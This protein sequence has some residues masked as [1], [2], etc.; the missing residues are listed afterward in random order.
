[1]VRTPPAR[2]T[3]IV[4]VKRLRAE[5]EPVQARDFLR[6]LFDW[7]LSCRT[8]GCKVRMQWPRCLLTRGLRA[9]AAAWKADI[10]PARI[11]EYD[12]HWLAETL[13]R[14]P[15]RMARLEPESRS[16][17]GAGPL[18]SP[19]PMLAKGTSRLVGAHPTARCGSSAPS[20]GVSTS[21]E[22][23]A[24]PF[25]M[26][27]PT[28]LGCCRFEVEEALAELVALGLVNSDSFGV[29]GVA[30]TAGSTKRIDLGQ[31]SRAAVAMFGMA[32][33]GNGPACG[34][35]RFGNSAPPR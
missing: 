35:M 16:N 24:L 28:A 22:S 15:L 25:S 23:R 11:A 30:G 7:R 32:D 26:T 9:P 18:R 29:T 12:P 17:K 31:A 34:A 1:M 3:S 13:S 2:A 21:S 33:A 14:G 27:L 6:F 4:H 8:R 20:A 5:I 10:I 19:H